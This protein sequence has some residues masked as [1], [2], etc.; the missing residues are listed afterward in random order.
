MKQT[1]K[2]KK[3]N[4]NN[5]NNMLHIKCFV[6][7]SFAYV[8]SVMLK[9]MNC[10]FFFICCCCY[11]YYCFWYSN[12]PAQRLHLQI[13]KNELIFVNL[14]LSLRMKKLSMKYQLWTEFYKKLCVK[15]LDFEKSSLTMRFFNAFMP[16]HTTRIRQLLD[17]GYH[18][19]YAIDYAIRRYVI[20]EI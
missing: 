15:N 3:T 20:P 16:E 13:Q 6:I 14:S 4:F 12:T 5:H 1:K 9:A 7:T 10:W 18:R 17:G 2:K 19:C 11:Y 8:R